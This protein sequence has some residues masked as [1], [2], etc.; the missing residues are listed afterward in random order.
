MSG[1]QT[2]EALHGDR[3]A[4]DPPLPRVAVSGS[5]IVAAN[6]K[7][8]FFLFLVTLPLANPWVRGDGVGYYAYLRS[9]LIDHDLRFENDFLAANESFV[10]SHIDEQ[11][12]LLPRLYTKTGYVENHFSVGPAILWAPVMLAVHGTV[13]LADR[14]GAHVAPDGYSPPYLLGM[15]FTTACYGFL[16]LF[17]AFR[18][19][20]KYFDGPW[21]FLATVGIWMASSLPIY[22]YFNPSWSHALS[23]FTVA[24]FLWYWDRTR[25]QRTAGQWALLGLMAGLMGNVYYPN[26]IMLIFPALEVVHLLFAKQRDPGQIVVTIQKLAVSGGVF[27]AAFFASLFPTFLTRQIIYGSPFETGYP[28]ISTWNWTSPV[29]FKVLFSSNHGMFSWTPILILAVAGLAFLIRRDALLGA[30]SLLTFLAFYYLIASY[31][32]WDGIS[33]FGNRFFVSLTPIFILG[34]AA[35]LGSFSSWMGKTTRAIAVSCSVLA[36]LV[37]WNAGFIFQWGTHMVPARGEI[38]WSAMVRNQVVDVPFR[39]THS[40]ETYFTRRDE[41][42]QNIEQEDIEQQKLQEKRGE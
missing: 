41:M 3:I 24:L 25:L 39:M 17:L 14:F 42:M 22:M 30:G 23:A 26:A 32:D 1:L 27:L 15:A 33:S 13:L 11:G 16:S 28:A 2:D 5:W 20:R 38:S 21:A 6:E 36:L 31:P 35:L 40:L 4:V 12:R 29:L 8:L 7:L 34:L 37:V 10:I 19:A 18:I 9:A